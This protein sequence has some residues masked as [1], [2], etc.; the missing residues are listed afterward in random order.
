MFSPLIRIILVR[1]IN[2]LFFR[3]SIDNFSNKNIKYKIQK[4]KVEKKKSNSEI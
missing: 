4:V 3:S 2:F 1:D